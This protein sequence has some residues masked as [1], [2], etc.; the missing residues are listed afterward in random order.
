[1]KLREVTLAAPNFMGPARDDQLVL[2]RSGPR[3]GPD[4]ELAL[5]VINGSDKV[6]LTETQL[7]ATLFHVCR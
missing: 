7:W 3:A 6:K 1:M 4:S 2:V 5:G